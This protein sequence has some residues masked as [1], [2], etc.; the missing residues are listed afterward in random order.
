MLSAVCTES[1]V[2]QGGRMP[3]GVRWDK[4]MRVRCQIEEETYPLEERL[5]CVVEKLIRDIRYLT[6][7][8]QPA[9]LG[10]GS[11]RGSHYAE[12]GRSSKRRPGSLRSRVGR[13]WGDDQGL[14]MRR[15]Q[16]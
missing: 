7:D 11:G 2:S 8:P 13:S 3:V 15:E 5:E 16:T 1:D 6:A 4:V 9:G 12:S 10:G 14:G